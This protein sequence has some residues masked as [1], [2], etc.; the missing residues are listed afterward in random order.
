MPGGFTAPAAP[1]SYSHQAGAGFQGGYSGVVDEENFEST[2]PA[3]AKSHVKQPSVTGG[4]QTAA[5]GGYH[6]IGGDE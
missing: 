1:S 5:T 6:S 3:P 4:Y 2:P